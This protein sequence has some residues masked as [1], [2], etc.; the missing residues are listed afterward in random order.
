MKEKEQNEKVHIAFG[1]KS[2]QDIT[3]LFKA[4]KNIKL[5]LNKS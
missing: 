3:T 1:I 4:L 2:P 5:E